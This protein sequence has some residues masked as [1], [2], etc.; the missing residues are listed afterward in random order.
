[1]SCLHEPS[2]M[3][4]PD[5]TLGKHGPIPT[6]F[7]LALG[8]LALYDHLSKPFRRHDPPFISWIHNFSG[9]VLTDER[10]ELSCHGCSKDLDLDDALMQQGPR[11]K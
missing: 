9:W 11:C 8:R 4:H 2:Q 5:E 6:A 10:P 3:V 7:G 1:M